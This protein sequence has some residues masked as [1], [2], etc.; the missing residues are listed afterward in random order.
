MATDQGADFAGMHKHFRMIAISEHLRSHGFDPDIYH[1]TRI[2]HIWELL[3]SYYDLELIDERES[4]EDDEPDD[5]YI[6]FSLPHR[7]FLQSMMQRAAADTSEAPTSPPALELSPSP[8]AQKKRKRGRPPSSTKAAVAAS[9]EDTDGGTD[10]P[11]SSPIKARGRGRPKKSA[12]Q[13]TK[14]ETTEEEDGD[15]EDEEGDESGSGDEDEES[16]EEDDNTPAARSTRKNVKK[17][18]KKPPPTRKT[19]SRK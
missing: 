11:S 19:R 1:H 18:S 14:A 16:A 6:D 12:E 7:Q 3:R 17:T 10:A 13:P 15:E 8:L 2:P 5:K 9:A 4:L